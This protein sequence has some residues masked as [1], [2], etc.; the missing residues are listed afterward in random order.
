MKLSWKLIA[1]NTGLVVGL[2]WG[3]QATGGSVDGHVAP[4]NPEFVKYLEMRARKPL[5][6]EWKPGLIPAPV[7]PAVLGG[8]QHPVKRS[9]A[10]LPATYDLRTTGRLSPVKNQLPYGTCW[11][12]ATM[13]ALESRLL[14]AQAWDFSENNLANLHG[15][16][17][18]FNDGGGNLISIACL[19]RWTGPVTES[20][21]PYPNPGL[22]PVGLPSCLHLQE[23]FLVSS[24]HSALDNDD[25]KQ[26]V[27]DY[28]GVYV[29]MFW[30]NDAYNDT[31]KSY[32][33]TGTNND[34]HAVVMVGWDDNFPANNFNTPAPGNGA[35]IIKNSFGTNWADHGY[36]YASYYD[37]KMAPGG[38]TVFGAE[39]VT[40]YSGVYQYDP[41]GWVTSVR[42][43][44]ETWGANI[45]TA[46]S[47][48]ALRAVS[49][50][51]PEYD[52]DYEIWIYRNVTE[53]Q[54]SSGL[55]AL[56]QTGTFTH[57]GYYTVR[58][59]TPVGL[60][61]GV[62]FSVVLNF[63]G[64][65]ATYPIRIEYA[66]S[67]YSSAATA[68]PGQSFF[69]PDGDNWEDLT[70]YIASANVCLKAFTG[71]PA[72]ATIGMTAGDYDADGIADL[73]AFRNG[74]WSIYSLTNGIILNNQG[75]WGGPGWTPVPGD[76]DGDGIADLAVYND[77]YWSIYSLVYGVIL[78]NQGPLGGAGSTPVPGDYDGDGKYDLAVYN[79]GYW[80][81]Y[82]LANGIILNNQGP[83]GG[84]DSI[85]VPGDY[86]GDG[87]SDLAVYRD[88]YWS[89]YSLANGI[90]LNNQGPWG[91]PGWIPV[92]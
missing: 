7:D 47:A 63:P 17:L 3:N 36:F 27:I 80:S 40:N 2:C 44:D 58:L 26:A 30:A 20:Q 68:S 18:D 87:E 88:G 50:Y 69:G 84:S 43:T 21:D 57:Q 28:G 12:H 75:P 70:D 78:N 35:F 39:S 8:R 19:A 33:Y 14:P 42:Y 16:D 10:S 22:S 66:C 76:Y 37:L 51:T 62:R 65:T 77:G 29:C 45:F 59:N 71:W 1:C 81:I 64:T 56:H 61:V 25:L 74:Y 6:D 49:F 54:P 38:C 55:L 46:T 24:R 53:N 13:G 48:C 41:F 90:I 85:P 23:A 89:I 32:Y 73:A 67:N 9:K 52:S 86:N 83:W 15:F 31:Y 5:L 4:L 79:N 92:H 72:E 82:S 11:A 60:A 91:G 34:N